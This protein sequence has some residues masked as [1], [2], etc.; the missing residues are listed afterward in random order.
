MRH[1][2]PRLFQVTQRLVGCIAVDENFCKMAGRVG[3]DRARFD[4]L[5]QEAFGLLPL[6]T[7]DGNERLVGEVATCR[8]RIRNRS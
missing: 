6:A 5:P 4:R 2:L 1:E 8:N 3:I 7:F